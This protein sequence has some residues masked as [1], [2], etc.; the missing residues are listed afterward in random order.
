MKRAWYILFI[1]F[2]IL[3]TSCDSNPTMK[4]FL[5]DHPEIRLQINSGIMYDRYSPAEELNNLYDKNKGEI[6]TVYI[7]E[8]K[9]EVLLN[10]NPVRIGKTNYW[11]ANSGCEWRCTTKMFEVIEQPK[12][13][14]K[15]KVQ[16]AQKEEVIM[17]LTL[18]TWIGI[19]I[20]V[21]I[22]V[23]VVPKVTLKR[24]FRPTKKGV[25]KVKKDW[26]EA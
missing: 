9:Y 4:E 25:E 2:P 11:V 10:K 16:K 22:A 24:I 1:V 12:P 14:P 26:D 20:I 7:Y 15:P 5:F 6:L 21:I 3:L 13:P 19:I 18:G 17:G 23:K 8:E